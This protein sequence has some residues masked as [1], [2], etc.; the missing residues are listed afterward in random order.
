MQINNFTVFSH[1]LEIFSIFCQT[2][3][4]INARFRAIQIS[5]FA[6]KN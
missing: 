6:V 3:N 1:F 5:I 2:V 4:Y